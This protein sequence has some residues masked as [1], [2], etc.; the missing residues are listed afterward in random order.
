SCE[1]TAL[2]QLLACRAPDNWGSKGRGSSATVRPEAPALSSARRPT[3]KR[4][5]VG[6]RSPA[7]WRYP[8]PPAGAAYDHAVARAHILGLGVISAK[9]GSLDSARNFD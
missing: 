5:G 6:E 7:E 9:T 1:L 2:W 4:A 3:V 8:A